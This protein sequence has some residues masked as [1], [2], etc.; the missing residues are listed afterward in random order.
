VALSGTGHWVNS[1]RCASFAEVYRDAVAAKATTW[2]QVEDAFLAAMSEFDK[3][4]AASIG[5]D[6]SDDEK[7]ELSAD[8]QNGK[9]DFFNDL[10]ALL[11]T[12][13]AGIGTLFTRRNI[14]G[15]IVPNHNLDGVYPEDGPIK[16]LLEAKMMGTPKHINSPKQV[17]HGRRGS[18]DIDKRVKELAF[19]CIDLKG[20]QSRRAAM[21]GSTSQTSG[22]GGSDLG[23]WLHAAQPNI[24]FFVAMRVV[25]E[26]DFKAA[27]RWASTAAQVLDA[28][29]LFCFEP[30][31]DTFTNYRIRTDVPTEL[32]LDRKLWAAGI[33]LA[34]AVSR[35]G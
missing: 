23:T 15:L 34:A 3:G 21:Q 18:A 33:D 29:G 1:A 9:G 10:L 30:V 25:N 24:Y 32:Q 26:A 13:H 7:S 6:M 20:E 22:P 28:V 27:I 35:S 14:P 19:K 2:N 17:A 12:N 5:S 31:D 4:I 8:L 11:L 16:F